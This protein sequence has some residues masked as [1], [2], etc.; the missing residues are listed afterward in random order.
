M[1]TARL[2]SSGKVTFSVMSVHQSVI[3]S[4]NREWIPMRPLP[5]MPFVSHRSHGTV[6]GPSL[7]LPLLLYSPY[8][9]LPGPDSPGHVQTCLIG[10]SPYTNPSPL[11]VKNSSLCRLDC[12]KVGGWYSTEMPFCSIKEYTDGHLAPLLW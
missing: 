6:L 8:M 10:K 1:I 9:D 11:H 3:L 7:S 12:Q 4:V 2:R 5:M